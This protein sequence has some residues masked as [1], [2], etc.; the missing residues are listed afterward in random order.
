[1]IPKPIL[2]PPTRIH[3]RMHHRPILASVVILV[4]RVDLDVFKLY[5]HR[6]LNPSD[7]VLVHHPL[8]RPAQGLAARS[9]LRYRY[10]VFALYSSLE[11]ATKIDVVFLI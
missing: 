8:A 11:I 9:E 7:Q 4:T 3:L 2:F 10:F 6:Y 5:R 1:M